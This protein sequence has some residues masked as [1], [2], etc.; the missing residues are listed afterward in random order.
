MAMFRFLWCPRCKTSAKWL[1]DATGLYFE[2][3]LYACNCGVAQNDMEPWETVRKIVPSLP[4]APKQGVVYGFRC[5]EGDAPDLQVSGAR[6]PP[7]A[8][9]REPEQSTD[10]L[11]AMNGMAILRLP[12]VIGLIGLRKTTIYAMVAKGLFPSPIP[13]GLRARGWRAGDVLAWIAD[14]QPA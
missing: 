9:P 6:R 5:Q 2:K 8:R 12:D 1:M 11:S 14:R 10:R 7:G 4:A 13:L 3:E